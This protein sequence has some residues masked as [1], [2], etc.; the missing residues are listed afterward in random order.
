MK[1]NGLRTKLLFGALALVTVPLLAAGIFFHSRITDLLESNG[2]ER[3]VQKSGELAELTQTS[4][5]QQLDAVSSLANVE[6][7]AATIQARNSRQLDA[8]ALTLANRQLG[9]LLRGL[10][11]HH[12]GIWLCDSEGTI[13]AGTLKGG[14]TEAYRS[15]DIKDRGYFTTARTT[16]KPTISDPVRSKI[17]DVP[18][19]VVCAP[20]TGPDG[21]FAGLV[22][23]SLEINYLIETISHDKLGVSGYPFAIDHRGMMVAHPDPKR[24]LS[25]DFKTVQGAEELARRMIA[26]ETGAE[27]YISSTGDRKVAAFSPVPLVGWSVAASMNS[28]EFI[29]PIR[30]MRW[31]LLTFLGICVLGAG[32]I[33]T[34]FANSVAAPLKETT[35]V[36]DDATAS[37]D[38]G[39]SEIARGAQALAGATSQQAA[40][41]EETSASLTEM[42][43]TTKSNAEHAGTAA[44]LTSAAVERIKQADGSMR[45]L[46]AAVTSV[47]AASEQTRKVIK[48]IDE[49]A[50]QTNILALNAAVEAA[51]AGV[52]GAGFAV[53]ADEVRS[54]AGRAAV[55]ARESGE[56]LQKVGDLILRSRDLAGT[57]TAEV[58]A[59]RVDAEKVGVLVKEIASSSN[60]QANAI[61][62]ITRALSELEQG[63]QEA[64]ATAEEAAGS[65][66]ELRSQAA[67]I[68][69]GTV[70]LQ[71][72]VD[73]ESPAE[74]AVP[75]PT[76][77]E[78]SATAGRSVRRAPAAAKPMLASAGRHS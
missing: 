78:V 64:A 37:M 45:E 40:S 65:S 66:E 71:Q 9:S 36:L 13:F 39:S 19:V 3:L 34:F 60:E 51:R 44:E 28:A 6:L 23:L 12:Q 25:L 48:T 53:V 16:G 61:D 75:N 15:L 21:R 1:F 18:I 14:E 38:A 69:A 57:T 32:T 62:Q 7:L 42:S 2:R 49:I 58:G 47:A 17:G 52:A 4:L 43:A 59:A 46:A 29:A 63:V 24:I 55:A 27:E 20:V 54:L 31:T 73:G 76:A 5:Q 11:T 72:I 68:R 77:R 33:A 22:G 50:F 30:A 8:N 26:G 41:I 35:A 67:R 74:P 10:G 56:T 70:V